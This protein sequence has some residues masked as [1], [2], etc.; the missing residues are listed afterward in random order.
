MCGSEQERIYR[1]RAT[2]RTWNLQRLQL[3]LG[4]NE[5]PSRIHVF[6]RQA[7]LKRT[8]YPFVQI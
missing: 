4:R 5:L 6:Y 3:G 2:R 8:A 1:S 7:L